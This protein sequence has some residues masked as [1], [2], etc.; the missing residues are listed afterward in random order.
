MRGKPAY[1][2][3]RLRTRGITPADAGKTKPRFRG[4][5]GSQDHPRGCGE[6]NILTICMTFARGS[7]PR[8]RG[9][10]QADC[11]VFRR[12]G[13]TPADA[14]K[15]KFPALLQFLPQDH[16]R[17]CGENYSAGYAR[18]SNMGSPP[19]M[20]GKQFC[21][22]C[23]GVDEGITPAD[24]GKTFLAHAI[25]FSLPDHPRGCGENYPI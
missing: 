3:C 6:N 5:S 15:T 8:M 10:P 20:R 18:T 11:H 23:K 1:A 7:P 14:G 16:P 19:R 2:R 4:F 24:A 13:I 25:C 17:G 9:K 22:A 12:Q 21:T